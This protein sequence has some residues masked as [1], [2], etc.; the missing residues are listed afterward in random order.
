M[1]IQSDSGHHNFFN[2][3]KQESPPKEEKGETTTK[4]ISQENRINFYKK[5][6]GEETTTTTNNLNTDTQI[7]ESND[8]KQ[9]VGHILENPEESHEHGEDLLHHSTKNPS[10]HHETEVTSTVSDKTLHINENY[11][12]N[13]DNKAD[14]KVHDLKSTN[15]KKRSKAVL[16]KN[17]P[18][19]GRIGELKAKDRVWKDFSSFAIEAR[20]DDY[21]SCYESIKEAEKKFISAGDVKGLLNHYKALKEEY[22]GPTAPKE[23]NVTGNFLNNLD[24]KINELEEK[25]KKNEL[26]FSD[27][28]ELKYLI[29]DEI[30]RNLNEPLSRYSK[31]LTQ[32]I[33]TK[34]EDSTTKT[35]R[36]NAMIVR[37]DFVKKN[38]PQEAADLYKAALKLG[39]REAKGKLTLLTIDLWLTDKAFGKQIRQLEERRDAVGASESQEAE[40]SLKLIDLKNHI[41]T[42]STLDKL[43]MAIT[44]SL[45]KLNTIRK[46]ILREVIHPGTVRYSDKSVNEVKSKKAEIDAKLADP[47]NWNKENGTLKPGVLTDEE[48]QINSHLNAQLNV[49][50]AIK[51]QEAQKINIYTKDHQQLDACVVFADKNE[52][53]VSK[54]K[55]MV[56]VQ[57]NLTSYEQAFKEAQLYAKKYGVNVLLFNNR[58]VG[59]SLG[60]E[61]G[62]KDAVEDCKAVLRYAIKQGIN[63]KDLGVLGQSL[64]GGTSST[65]LQE[66][67]KGGELPPDGVG[68]YINKHSFSS[69]HGFALG[70]VKQKSPFLLALVKGCMSLIGFNTLN[71]HANITNYQL[72][73][74]VVVLTAE[75]D[76]V[77]HGVG[78]A[79]VSLQND[80]KAT[81]KVAEGKLQFINVTGVKHNTDVEYVTGD[82]LA[83]KESALA[84][85]KKELSKLIQS[86]TYLKNSIEADEKSI[87]EYEV[88]LAATKEKLVAAKEKP[89]N[90]AVEELSQAVQ[91][92]ES[93]LSEIKFNLKTDKETLEKSKE[94]IKDKQETIESEIKKMEQEIT[95][96]QGYH[97]TLQDWSNPLPPAQSPGTAQ[98]ELPKTKSYIGKKQ[99]TSQM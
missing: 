1:S 6:R 50:E 3:E 32:R 87:P 75:K 52:P 24:K 65:A 17:D 95:E 83:N 67:I 18:K 77:M 97:N 70:Y 79:S 86:Q 78:K 71:T 21:L 90:K 62:T 38:N 69:L 28:S 20:C 9:V 88:K 7:K 35:A 72:A 14:D 46:N 45:N 66:L 33:N 60:K 22:F 13:V 53:D 73:N 23:L 64:G 30:N 98:A 49:A 15:L 26:S 58:G 57:G 94:E 99:S 51:N 63:P 2:Y 59:Q 54:K 29:T 85:K 4:K 91:A 10:N 84:E 55:M 41:K 81:Q 16:K 43:S 56:M 76:E 80:K 68:V 25:S 89:D 12:D 96:L 42:V 36:S 34:D 61:Y 27:L 44:R 5:R 39:N 11:V 47:N 48:F 8:T 92:Q 40:A 74:K 31:D 37:G 93:L 19:E 82:V